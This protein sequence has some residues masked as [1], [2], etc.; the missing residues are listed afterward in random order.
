[1]S[2][3]VV[4]GIDESARS[5]AALRVADDLAKRCDLPLSV[6]NVGPATKMS[7]RPSRAVRLHEGMRR[8]LGRDAVPLII[9]GGDPAERLAAASRRATVLVV[10]NPGHGPFRHGVQ[11][12]VV[13]SLTR[14]S[15]CPVIVAPRSA[16]QSVST[17]LAGMRI[18][19]AVRDERD[20]S[21]AATAGCWA[22]DLG[23]DITLARAIELPPIRSVAI[24]EPPPARPS[25]P[26]A[27]AAAATDALTVV[28]DAISRVAAV[29]VRTCV[30]FGAPAR[31]LRAIAAGERA[32]LIIVGPRRHGR[33]GE[34]LRTSP[35]AGLLRSCAH[36]VMVCPRPEA[37][38]TAGL[39]VARE[40]PTK[41]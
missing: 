26:R 25:T 24:A 18:V 7:P 40:I 15:A 36:P 22:A 27:R 16:G 8:V 20:L 34:A 4:C 39:R 35:T 3:A 14:Q 31:Q 37:V 28:A 23:L 9:D 38:F 33:L 12:S 30:A 29:D 21:C 41:S 17:G 32:Y 19:C 11:L 2:S 1:M 10:G 5:W 6:L 13:A